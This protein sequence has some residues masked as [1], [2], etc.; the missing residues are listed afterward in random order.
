MR[1]RA[2]L[3]RMVRRVFVDPLYGG[4]VAQMM[5]VETFRD[6][7]RFR[8]AVS[9]SDGE[10]KLGGHNAVTLGRAWP[11]VGLNARNQCRFYRDKW[12]GLAGLRR[13]LHRMSARALGRAVRVNNPNLPLIERVPRFVRQ[14]LPDII[15]FARGSAPQADAT[16]ARQF[17]GAV[18]PRAQ[19]LWAARPITC[20]GEK[21]T[22]DV[23]L[24]AKWRAGVWSAKSRLRTSRWGIYCRGSGCQDHWKSWPR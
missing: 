17:P 7:A 2:I 11:R 15:N 22:E 23:H 1:T 6:D 3:P 16:S 20:R 18:G 5:C 9:A 12:G 8:V 13:H 4:S 24:P 19:L 21:L 10:H 14:A